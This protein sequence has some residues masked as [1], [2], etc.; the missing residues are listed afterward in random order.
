M[1]FALKLTQARSQN[2]RLAITTAA[3]ALFVEQGYEKT[4]MEE[5]ALRAGISKA[6]IFAHFSSK[7]AILAVL[8]IADLEQLLSITQSLTE[9]GLPIQAERLFECYQPW[10]DYFL[11]NP[12]FARLYLVQSGLIVS[13][14]S[15]AYVAL[16]RNH[17]ML[18]AKAIFASTPNLGPKVD[19]IVRGAQAHFEQALVYRLSGWL[20]SDQIAADALKDALTIWCAGIKSAP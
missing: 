16:C 2:T 12:D 10:L 7:Q 17:Q 4:S 19:M 3:K 13:E 15:R 20:A 14:E 5:L 8:G 18:L 6:S 9:G 11:K 1:D